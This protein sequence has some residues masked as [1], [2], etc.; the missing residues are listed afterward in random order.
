MAMC[1]IETTW[2]ITLCFQSMENNAPLCHTGSIFLF[3]DSIL[4]I[5]LPTDAS[6]EPAGQTIS[7][8]IYADSGTYSA[9][10]KSCITASTVSILSAR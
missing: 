4:H 3:Q 2:H 1:Q 5:I 10:A 8:I 7:D 6:A 9:P